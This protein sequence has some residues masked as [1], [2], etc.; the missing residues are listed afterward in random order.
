MLPYASK[1][2]HGMSGNPSKCRNLGGLQPFAKVFE[3]QYL[4]QHTEPCI[5][6]YRTFAQLIVS[7]PLEERHPIVGLEGSTLRI[8]PG[9]ATRPSTMGP[10]GAIANIAAG[11]GRRG[12]GSTTAK[13]QKADTVA[14]CPYHPH[15]VIEDIYRLTSAIAT[16]LDVLSEQGHTQAKYNLASRIRSLRNDKRARADSFRRCPLILR[17]RA[18]CAM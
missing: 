1:T 2:S 12:A 8:P 4:D 6:F 11:Q 5:L 9:L 3:D 7:R 14:T 15:A 17:I 16:F 18:E 13:G 10:S